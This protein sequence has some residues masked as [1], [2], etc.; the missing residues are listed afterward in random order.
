MGILNIT[1]DSFSDGGKYFDGKVLIEKVIGDA[2]K[3]EIEGADFLDIGGE[4]TRPGAEEISLDEELE[5]VVPVISQLKRHIRIPISIDTY[6]SRVAEEALKSG[7]EIVNDISGFKFDNG[8]AEVTAKYKATCILMHIK[9]TPKN[10]Q[11]NPFYEDVVE[12]VF[13]YLMESISIAKGYSIQQII[14][15]AGIGFGKTLEHNLALISNLMRFKDLGYPIILGVSRKSFI[16][17]IY[18][19]KENE[20]LEGTIAA[21]VIG[22]LNGANIIRVHDVLE[23]KRAVLVVNKLSGKFNS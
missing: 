5:R 3:M 10:M 21:N 7:A 13:N 14:T 18:T 6:K 11:V 22:I 19:A 12:E 17:K 20:R 16:N 2:I 8:I 4:S 1:P 15:D 23:N 9:G